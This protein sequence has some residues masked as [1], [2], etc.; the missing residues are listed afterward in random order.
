MHACKTSHRGNAR[1]VCDGC[2]ISIEV[3]CGE[4]AKNNEA[5]LGIG[6]EGGDGG[7][8]GL[9]CGGTVGVAKA[10]NYSRTRSHCA[11]DC[12][13]VNCAAYG[14]GAEFGNVGDADGERELV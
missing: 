11:L 12:E 2:S 6:G 9:H 7:Y 5:G 3:E 10:L 1:V 8:E 13:G 14:N 4:T